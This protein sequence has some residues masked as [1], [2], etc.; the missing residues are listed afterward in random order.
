M[1]NTFKFRKDWLNCLRL[2]SL[3]CNLVDTVTLLEKT[4]YVTFVTKTL[5]NQK[6]IV[7]S[8][9]SRDILIIR[10]TYFGQIPWPLL[11]RFSSIMSTRKKSLLF[12]ICNI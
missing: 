6:I 1:K 7:L 10:N 8:F 4:L 2:C 3:K 9:V 5:L 12:K 11:R